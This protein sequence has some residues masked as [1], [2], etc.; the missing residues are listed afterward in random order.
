MTSDPTRTR[1]D[2]P[3]GAARADIRTR[4]SGPETRT[5]ADGQGRRPANDRPGPPPGRGRRRRRSRP[6]RNRARHVLLVFAALLVLTF[7]GAGLAQTDNGD[8]PE[9]FGVPLPHVGDRGTYTATVVRPSGDVVEVLVPER[10]LLH[11]EWLPARTTYDHAGVERRVNDLHIWPFEIEDGKNEPRADP[12]YSFDVASGKMIL[13]S[14]VHTG[15]GP[16]PGE[17][18]RRTFLHTE[19]DHFVIFCGLQNHLQGKSVDIRGKTDLFRPCSY[20]DHWSPRGTFVARGSQ[21]IGAHDTVLFAQ[22]DGGPGDSPQ[23]K[24]AWMAE[25]LPYPVRLTVERQDDPGTFIV[26]RLTGFERGATPIDTEHLPAGEPLAPL[27]Y[28]PV[29]RWGP[30]PS[31]MTYDFA[32]EDAVGKALDHP[33]ADSLRSYV[34]EHPDWYVVEARNHRSLGPGEEAH[35][36]WEVTLSE[37]GDGFSFKII[38]DTIVVEEWIEV[39]GR[40]VAPSGESHIEVSYRYEVGT[41]IRGAPFPSPE[42]FPDAGVPTTASV[43]TWWQRHASPEYAG[44]ASDTMRF[45]LNCRNEACKDSWYQLSVGV[46]ASVW[47]ESAD[48]E[49]SHTSEESSFEVLE[50]W[51]QGDPPEYEFLESR[52]VSTFDDD[53]GGTQLGDGP[54]DFVPQNMGISVWSFPD[55]YL[56]AGAGLVTIA[57]T[58]LYAAWPAVKAGGAWGLFS[59][60]TGPAL[61]DHP[62]RSR[63]Y[64]AIEARPGIHMQQLAD[65]TGHPR[66]TAEHHIRKLVGSGLVQVKAQ[67]GYNCIYPAR[68]VDRHVVA[69]LPYLKAKGARK[70]FALIGREPGTTGAEVAQRCGISPST[71]N[72]HVGKLRGAGLVEAERGAAGLHLRLSDLGATVQRQGH[73]NEA[74]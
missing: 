69:T 43:A 63:L 58:G 51:F 16:T 40:P 50:H 45:T 31:G 35:R 54:A 33:D 36:Q 26:I 68:G 22:N 24:Y 9:R 17:T 61:L 37:G 70:V 32:L 25:D 8:S 30:D 59:R 71:V 15:S 46:Q 38:E 34:D 60:V 48:G 1:R 44:Q 19:P 53:L 39:A 74:S 49:M 14:H 64:E 27:Q 11:F 65:A 4:T 62:V 7:V 3:Q 10:T 13:S 5:G 67:N 20:E 12:V 73:V 72:Y 57:L 52:H 56:L 21:R 6:A 28:A 18:Y 66:Q 55:S 41:P 29:G 23:E 2:A 42:A 47:T